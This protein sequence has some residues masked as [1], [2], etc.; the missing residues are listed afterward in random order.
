MP[1]A[2][3]PGDR[4]WGYDGVALF[5]P[6]H[7]Y[8]TPEDFKRL[9]DASHARGL[10]VLLDVVYNHLGPDGNYLGRFGP[11]FSTDYT[12][13]WGEAVNLDGPGSDEV[14][15]FLCDN[16]LGWLE[17]YHLD[18]LRLDAVHAFLDRSAQPFLEQ[19]SREVA[20]LGQRL[21]RPKVLIAETDLNDPRLVH[22]LEVGGCGCDAEWSDDFHHSLHALLTRERN[23]Y[24]AD[25]GELADLREALTAGFVYAGR[26]SAFRRRSQGR[27]LGDVPLSRLVG[28]LQNHD[29]V[30]NRVRGD[31]IGGS[32]SAE[33]LELAAALVLTGPFV[34]LIFQGE[35]WNAS[36]P[37]RYFTDHQSAE[38]ARAVTVG[39]QRECVARGERL[40]SFPD[41]QAL[42]TFQASKLDWYEIVLPEHRALL[43]WYSTLIR[44]RRSEPDLTGAEPPQVNIDVGGRWLTSQRGRVLVAANFSPG[45]LGL[46]AAAGSRLLLGSRG[47]EVS[48]GVLTLPGWGVGIL[49]VPS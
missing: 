14:R 9:V 5:A 20:A 22:R 16:A 39:R 28:Y 25:F 48:S 49:R 32:L 37:F 7:V 3:F 27:P 12:T 33:Q 4:G 23:G 29:Q 10:A 46:S 44:L 2:E 6:Y 11:Y 19:L 36:S 26:Y 41:P 45:P 35:E 40:E 30:G 15:R 8:G 17:L 24:Y 42:E 13:P 38:L 34:P 47:A 43:D 31:R 1:I 18:G 21:G